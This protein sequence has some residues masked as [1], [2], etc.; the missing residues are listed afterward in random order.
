[1]TTIFPWPSHVVRWI[2]F[3][4]RRST[5]I[6]PSLSGSTAVARRILTLSLLIQ[7]TG[8]SSTSWISR[9]RV[10]KTTLIGADGTGVSHGT[11]GRARDTNCFRLHF[12]WSPRN[13]PNDWNNSRGREACLAGMLDVHATRGETSHAG[14]KLC[15]SQ[16]AGIVSADR[17]VEV[18]QTMFPFAHS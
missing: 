10:L 14:Q 3:K 13:S 9:H 11:C 12:T 15:G 2:L 16:R 5:W 7:P 4:W 18:C 1:M 8:V 17:G 6:L